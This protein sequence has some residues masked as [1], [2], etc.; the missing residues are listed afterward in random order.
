MKPVER[1]LPLID[2]SGDPKLPAFLYDQDL[3]DGSMTQGLFHGPLLLAASVPLLV[4]W[5]VTNPGSFRFTCK[6]LYRH[7]PQLV[8]RHHQSGEM[9][10]FMA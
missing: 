1:E 5:K 3:A 2:S 6:S 10:G 9:Q 7:L 4:K 8:R